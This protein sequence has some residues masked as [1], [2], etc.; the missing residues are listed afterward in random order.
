MHCVMLGMLFSP[1]DACLV[2]FVIADTMLLALLL[3]PRY[4]W[5]EL[6]AYFTA[7]LAIVGIATADVLHRLGP[8]AYALF[9][10]LWRGFPVMNTSTRMFAALLVVWTVS[11]LAPGAAGET[12][13][14]VVLATICCWGGYVAAVKF[15]A[16]PWSESVE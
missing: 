5:L 11:K 13:A 14:H 2:W 15:W 10:V 8:F 9:T 7:A 6:L 16:L 4:F 1:A 3:G 12:L